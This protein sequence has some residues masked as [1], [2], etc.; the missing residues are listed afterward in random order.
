M[1]SKMKLI[2]RFWILFL[3]YLPKKK[4]SDLW[5]VFCFEYIL[6]LIYYFFTYHLFVG[7]N[8]KNQNLVAKFYAFNTGFF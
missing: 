3:E 5:K 6:V 2:L 1:P 7:I 8:F 4:P